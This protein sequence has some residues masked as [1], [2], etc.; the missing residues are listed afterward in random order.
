MLRG[1][2]VITYTHTHIVRIEHT[3]SAVLH[4]ETNLSKDDDDAATAKNH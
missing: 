4:T 2:N 1:A 3:A